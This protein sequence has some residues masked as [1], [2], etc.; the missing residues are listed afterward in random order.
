[1][2][3]FTG[4][5]NFSKTFDYQKFRQNIDRI[6]FPGRVARVKEN[7]LDDVLVNQGKRQKEARFEPI[8]SE[9][10]S[11]LTLRNGKGEALDLIREFIIPITNSVNPDL[12]D[13]TVNILKSPDNNGFT[14]PAA[15]RINI[16]QSWI[17]NADRHQGIKVAHELGHLAAFRAD[18][19]SRYL[20]DDT[21]CQLTVIENLIENPDMSKGDMVNEFIGM[22]NDGIISDLGF[23]DWPSFI[24][25]I[26]QTVDK[27]QTIAE[28]L[29]EARS[30]V[31]KDLKK[32]AYIQQI[33]SEK[34][35]WVF[36]RKILEES[37]K[38]GFVID[39]RPEAEI[40]LTISAS[41]GS[42]VEPGVTYA[43]E[44]RTDRIK[45]GLPEFPEAE[46]DFNNMSVEG[47]LNDIY[48]MRKEFTKHTEE[49]IGH[50][51]L[52]DSINPIVDRE[53]SLNQVDSRTIIGVASLF[54]DE[55]P[56]QITKIQETQVR[57]IIAAYQLWTEAYF[58]NAEKTMTDKSEKRRHLLIGNVAYADVAG[59]P[60]RHQLMF[61]T[62]GAN[63]E[64]SPKSIHG[65]SAI[66]DT[67]I[68]DYSVMPLENKKCNY[69][70]AKRLVPE[71]GSDF[72]GWQVIG[73]MTRIRDLAYQSGDK[74]VSESARIEK[75]L[76]DTGYDTSDVGCVS[77]DH[78]GFG[79]F[80]K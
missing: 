37:K 2:V 26:S 80:L 8:T 36:T 60:N 66:F 19:S 29:P 55:K 28:S 71:N 35:A 79:G 63:A 74:T 30:L 1:M 49:Y 68:H 22:K 24:D 27:M 54:G 41:L 4:P 48:K 32:Q 57:L 23:H 58:Q 39:N 62:I 40:S 20:Y 43:V 33:N 59:V 38:R 78:V 61:R 53:T 75:Y 14:L 21:L 25:Y 72:V 5:E 17:S 46:P 56:A 45:L 47:L 7:I 50:F 13:P 9:I 67:K 69:L 70:F 76:A 73:E 77:F 3:E 11:S 12:P 65:F 51:G 52:V 10:S 18:P 44:N 64:I 34:A 15:G 31:L 6:L 16:P 42:R